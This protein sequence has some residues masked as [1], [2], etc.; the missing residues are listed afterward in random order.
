MRKS[1][2][3]VVISVFALTGVLEVRSLALAE[4]KVL[5]LDGGASVEANNYRF[6]NNTRSAYETSKS[7]GYSTSVYA[8][9]GN[10]RVSQ[11]SNE[12]L[13]NYSLTPDGTKNQNP[14]G[15]VAQKPTYPP[16]Q[17]PLRSSEDM[18]KAIAALN[19]KPGDRLLIQMTGHGNLNEK[20]EPGYDF[21]GTNETWK[22]VGD[23]LA[24]VDPKVTVQ[25]QASSCYAGG[26]HDLAKRFPNV[27]SASSTQ[28]YSVSNS[29]NT[30]D[31]FTNAFWNNIKSKSGTMSFGDASV[32]G[33]KADQQNTS[34]GSLS[35]FDYM[36]FV[37][38]KS[39][40]DQVQYKDYKKTGTYDSQ[41]KPIFSMDPYGRDK[42]CNIDN[43][44]GEVAQFTETI[45]ALNKFTSTSN[46][47][48]PSGLQL[49]PGFVK[50]LK[51]QTGAEDPAYQKYTAQRAKL[52]QEW[53][54]HQAK[55][56]NS[57][58]VTK[59]WYDEGDKRAEIERKIY[60][61]DT[62]S[63]IPLYDHYNLGKLKTVVDNLK[64]FQ[65]KA[66]PEQKTK[67]NQILACE[68]GTFK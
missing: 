61:L 68:W 6:Y 12:S 3:S 51:E 17:G 26:V 63:G 37:L 45:Q 29:L 66:T 64:E 59:W 47:V 38:K 30:G 21:Y 28:R 52:Q 20:G 14:A 1:H 4:T 7:L 40:Y 67:L 5:L 25:I 56:K 46:S 60:D 35:S 15:R 2:S 13:S 10:W 50:M 32:A 53:N 16:V 49:P 39:P 23:A 19:L 54:E 48:D 41:Y 8:K 43:V 11:N 57:W 18:A 9:D 27:C 65:A 58:D 31:A 55:F 24:K 36:A 62:N 34:Q 42:K 22:T 44:T 33:F